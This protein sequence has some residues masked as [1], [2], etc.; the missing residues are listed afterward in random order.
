MA[1]YRNPAAQP[2]TLTKEEKAKAFE[3]QIR[4]N[5]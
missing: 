3:M 4:E 1:Q 5:F 2:E